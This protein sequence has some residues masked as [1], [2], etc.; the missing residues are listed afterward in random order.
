MWG[1]LGIITAASGRVARGVRSRPSRAI[2]LVD[3]RGWAPLP[4]ASAAYLAVAMVNLR[5]NRLDE[6]LAGLEQ[7][8]RQSGFD[9]VPRCALAFHPGRVARLGGQAR[10][11]PRGAAP[12]ASPARRLGAVGLPGP[13]GAR[14]PRPRSTWPKVSTPRRWTSCACWR[15]QAGSHLPS[16][17][18]LA[19]RVAGGLGRPVRR[20]PS[21]SKLRG[22]ERTGVECRCLGWLSVAC[23]GPVA[24]GQPSL[25]LAAAAPCSGAERRRPPAVREPRTRARA[26]VAGPPAAGGIPAW[27]P[28]C[29][30]WSAS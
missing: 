21:C 17:L 20:T 22:G 1:H 13:G 9:L 30:S 2:D 24:R 18:C 7:G 15:R 8:Q 28:S 29:G 10:R 14:S 25:G 6:A 26:P 5:W 3:A 12:P 23:R 4:Q 11:C 27:T 16:R 19:T